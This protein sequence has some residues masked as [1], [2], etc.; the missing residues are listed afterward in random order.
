M[1]VKQFAII[2]I[3][4]FGLSLAHA[5]Y[6]KGHDVLVIDNDKAKVQQI[7]DT[8]THAVHADSANEDVIK[9]LGLKN[10]DVA[11]IAIG[12]D[13]QANI[14]T[15][16]ILKEEGCPYIVAK[17]RTS[18][19]AKVLQKIGVDRIVFPEK[20]MALRMAHSLI[21]INIVDFIELSPDYS[22]VEVITPDN[23]VDLTLN[24][25]QLRARY[26]I[27]V[28]AVRSEKGET[29]ISPG[30]DDHLKNGDIMVVVGENKVLHKL[31]W[32]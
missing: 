1:K 11:V 32:L 7:S 30:A 18:L 2:G 19:H 4:R 3:G 17:A 21:S 20:D 31:N 14:L 10:Y 22:I 8:V 23:M 28:V 25:L 27:N 15:A 26:G 6:K 24:E 9:K 5:L 29:N 13:I 16:I 12:H